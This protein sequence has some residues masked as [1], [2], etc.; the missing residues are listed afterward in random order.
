MS[1]LSE[2][3]A[4]ARRLVDAVGNNF[5]SDA[6]INDYLN[7]GLGEL[8]DLLVLK[9]EDYYVSSI[10][11]NMA[12][13]TSSY[14]L[15]SIGLN[16][17]YKLLGVDLKQGSETVRVPRYSFQERNTFK[18]SQAL[19]SDRGHTNHRYSLTGNNINFIPT[20][21]S[22]DEV[23]L[24][25][26]PKYTK[27]VNDSDSVDGSIASNWEDYA[28]YSAAIKM[29]QKEETSVTSL[30]REQEKITARIEEAARNRDAG[31]PMG[32]TDE[33]MGVLAGHWLFR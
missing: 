18:S 1:T 14:S 2:L 3:R 22:S 6:E 17:L 33:D 8:H 25:Y 4:R 21:T 16:N 26:V 11:F 32:I 31:E 24:W 13:D 9:F 7:T 10:S 12:S 28:V 30:E 19:Y 20:P 29:R 27:L 15:Q 5:F 23:T